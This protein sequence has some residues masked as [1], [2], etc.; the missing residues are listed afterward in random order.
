MVDKHG[1]LRFVAVPCTLYSIPY[2]ELPMPT[3]PFL[4]LL[5]LVACSRDRQTSL[6]DSLPVSR[7]SM[8]V[9]EP[10]PPRAPA[11]T[12]TTLP[13][14]TAS[15]V[16]VERAVINGVQWGAS[17]SDVQSL[18][19]KPQTTAGS[20]WQYP[21]LRIELAEGR[22]AGIWCTAPTCITG[23]AVRVGAT[24]TEV[25]TAYGPG[26]REATSIRYPFTADGSCALVF[27][28]RQGQVS[29]INVTCR[30]S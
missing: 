24:P 17:E 7:D 8:P 22:V 16:T 15:P 27:E 30:P 9:S 10:Q 25:E 3:R 1:R 12:D 23:D 13:A 28:L 4:L 26:V 2:S 19:G 21:G 5:T 14:P 18:L 20:V 29:A 11:D 6:A